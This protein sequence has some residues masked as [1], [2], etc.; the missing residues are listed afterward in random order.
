MSLTVIITGVLIALN[1]SCNENVIPGDD[2]T[3]ATESEETIDDAVAGNDNDHDKSS[4]YTWDASEVRY[5]HLEGAVITGDTA[6]VSY[7]GNQAVIGSAGVYSIDGSLSD[8][9]IIVDAGDDDVVKVILDGAE[10]HCSNSSPFTIRNADKVIIHLKEQTVN[11]LSDG[12][13]Y[14][15][16]DAD[17][18]EPSAALFSKADL[19]IFGNGSLT[20]QGNFNDAISSKDGLI[21]AS[22]EYL[23]TA[24]DDGIRGKDYL[25]IKDGTFTVSSGGDG[26]KSDNDDDLTR[27]Y[28][29]IQYGDFVVT[30]ATDALSASTDLMIAGGTF[31]LTS[32]GGSNSAVL[33]GVSSK[34]IKAAVS[35]IIDAGDF[36][37]S[38]ADD[39]VHSNLGMAI[40]GGTFIISTGDD[41][42]HA[43]STL[44]VNDGLITID[45]CY[46]GM[47]SAVLTFNGGDIHI[48]SSDDG[49]NG[50]GG[51]TTQTGGGM[52][53]PGGGFTTGNYYCY[54]NG[55]YIY[56]DARGDGID[57]GGTI[58]MTGGT[59]IV[60]GPTGN[61]D[62][63]IDYDVAYKMTGG[64]MLA[65][66]SSGMAETA[67]TTS[68]QYAILVGFSTTQPAG[69]LVHLQNSS[70]E[71]I[72]TFSPT[73]QYQSLAYCSPALSKGSKYEVYLGGS[74]TGSEKDGLYE[75]DAY[76]PG[77]LNST[78]T[79]STI[80]T[81]LNIR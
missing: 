42:F 23:I 10:L 45:Q 12:S 75:A 65:V 14:V 51:S 43:D 57:I 16:D 59:V 27:G 71:E 73:K 40:N 20:V 29:Y 81:K 38:S 46:E 8:G 52:M 25:I 44:L 74:D 68:T 41:G 66:G 21:I 72:L 1:L 76:T 19:T 53:P 30:S 31:N 55:G 28:L 58:N 54:I 67:G 5:I 77:T 70:G 2:N 69:T 9:R 32:G 80:V 6:G 3:G 4:D 37:I 61:M 49:L 24:K 50:A 17:E 47:E 64:T 18:E 39:A 22:G 48:T 56:I 78:L 36:G 60:N 34:G 63:A 11:I 15:Y 13:S 26:M 7:D 62:G 79:I 33:S 35:L